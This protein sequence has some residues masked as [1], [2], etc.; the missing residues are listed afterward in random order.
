MEKFQI[1]Q[2]SK[3]LRPYVKQYWFLAI[4]NAERSSQRYVPSGCAML[5]FHR[6]DRIYSTLH[7]EMQPRASLCGQSVF[8]TDTI[9]S[10][11][12]N[13]I[14]VVFQPVAARAIFGIPMNNIREKNID[15]ELLGDTYLSDLEKCLVDIEDNYKSV[16]LIEQYLLK[17]LY[18]YTSERFDRMNTVVQSINNG[19]QDIGELSKLAC[20]GYK[21]FKR[22]FAEYIGLN[23]KEFL[24]I[25]RFRKTSHSLHAGEQAHLNQLAYDGGYCDKSHLIKDFRTF[26][27]Y[28]PKEYL[29]ICDPYSEYMS[30]FNSIFIN[31]DCGTKNKRS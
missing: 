28:T 3:L 30:L 9:Y 17:K 14:A 8:Y 31:G 21:Q 23:P 6:G 16:Y 2:P 27:G 19:Q 12:L 22:V 5:A 20:L 18:S 1:I 29:S 7:R 10:G 11:N 26:T 4:D 25:A 13:L 24:Q 15:I